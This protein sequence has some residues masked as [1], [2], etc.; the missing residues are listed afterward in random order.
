MLNEARLTP[1]VIRSVVNDFRL[2]DPDLVDGDETF[3]DL[4]LDDEASPG[5]EVEEE[6]GDNSDAGDLG[7]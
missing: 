1:E 3:P 2:T 4:L 7:R 6:G 5:S